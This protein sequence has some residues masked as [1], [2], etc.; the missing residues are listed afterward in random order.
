WLQRATV[1]YGA[2]AQQHRRNQMLYNTEKDHQIA[3]RQQQ[4]TLQTERQETQRRKNHALDI[5]TELK[6]RIQ[7]IPALRSKGDLEEQRKQLTAKL[8]EG[9]QPLLEQDQQ[10]SANITALRNI[11]DIL[12]RHS[13][14]LL[15]PE[16]ASRGWRNTATDLLD[17]AGQPLPD[18]NQLL[19]RD[20]IDLSPLEAGIDHSRDEQTLHNALAAI[21][22]GDEQAS[23][24][25]TPA[26]SQR[27]DRLVADRERELH[28][29]EQEQQRIEQQIN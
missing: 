17:R 6:A 11:R 1:S 18:L 15:L 13:L 29:I 3:L 24:R 7:G 27:L 19:A 21:L 22:H 28:G 8:H 4:A 12:N 9:A 25:E 16:L 26:L 2:A 10:R 14:E 23:K 5:L 20:W